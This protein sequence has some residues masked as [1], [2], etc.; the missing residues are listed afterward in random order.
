M[1]HLRYVFRP[2]DELGKSHNL[3]STNAFKAQGVNFE[4][5][6][7]G[8]QPWTFRDATAAAK[9]GRPGKTVPGKVTVE[10]VKQ[11][12]RVGEIVRPMVA[13]G[14]GQSVYIQDQQSNC[15]IWTLE[16]LQLGTWEKITGC[17]VRRVPLVMEIGP[18]KVAETAINPYS[19]LFLQGRNPP[20]FGEGRY[21]ISF[22]YLLTPRRTETTTI[23]TVTSPEF[24]VNGPPLPT[25]TQRASE[26]FFNELEERRQLLPTG[27]IQGED[28]RAR[29]D[30]DGDG[31]CDDADRAFFQA[32]IGACRG[33]NNLTFPLCCFNQISCWLPRNT[34]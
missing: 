29:C 17:E 21:R 1:F 5:V 19:D 15:S 16:H 13:N 8:L 18:G 28:N 25:P 26:K 22:S 31:D 14:L 4:Y 7:A 30:F 10:L 24:V 9:L 20:A 6:T 3:L 23:H 34:P 32:R 33:D 2:E 12:F 27:G 11:S